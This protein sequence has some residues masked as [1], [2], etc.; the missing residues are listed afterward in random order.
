MTPS[1]INHKH[2][3]GLFRM[4]FSEKKDLLSLYNAIRGTNYRN[5]EEL[6]VT[7]L[8][9]V[10]YL[11]YKNDISFIVAGRLS[12]YEHQSTWSGNLPLRYLFY[13]SHL[14]SKL[15]ADANL[16]GSKTIPLPPPHFVVFF[17]GSKD[18]PDRSIHKL[19]DAYQIAD[20]D[21]NL[22]LKVLVLNINKG[23]NAELMK[24]C[25][26]LHDYAF[27]IQAIKDAPKEFSIEEAIEYAINLCIQNNILVDFLTA[28][29]SEV[30]LVSIFEYD[31]QKH[32]AQEKEE[33][34]AEGRAEGIAAIINSLKSVNASEKIIVQQLMLQ[35][36]LSEEE[37]IH[38]LKKQD[39]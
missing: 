8:E 10:I 5:T 12:L 13:I 28:H 35:M 6:V 29:R 11:S 27:L 23:H 32:I 18:M 38:H 30:I 26:T 31:A 2:K 25:K 39:I 19:S 7:T 14:Y 15:T 24:Q 22:E 33:S 4:L 20:D 37:A 21:I 16:Y 34:Y 9:D 17:N 36:K 3:D 1:T